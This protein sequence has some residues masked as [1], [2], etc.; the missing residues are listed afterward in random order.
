MIASY[1]RSATARIPSYSE[2]DRSAAA[3]QLL[4]SLLPRELQA[5]VQF[6]RRARAALDFGMRDPSRNVSLREVASH[7]GMEKTAFCRYFKLKVGQ[8]YGVVVRMLRV[9]YAADLL[10]RSDYAIGEVG[11]LAGFENRATFG[12]LFRAQYGVSPSA[13]RLRNSPLPFAHTDL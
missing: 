9:H 3:A 7:I 13:Y 12:R 11:A 8:P 6:H 2:P 10:R 4:D 1:A 5:C